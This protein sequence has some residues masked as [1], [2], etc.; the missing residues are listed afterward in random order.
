[1]NAKKLHEQQIREARKIILKKSHK[2]MRLLCQRCGKIVG[3]RTTTP[4]IYTEEVR[5]KYVCVMCR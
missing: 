1:M 4:E 5:K 3:L 2:T